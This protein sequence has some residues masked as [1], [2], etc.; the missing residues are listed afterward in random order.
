MEKICFLIVYLTMRGD[1]NKKNNENMRDIV[2]T[3]K[4]KVECTINIAEC[5]DD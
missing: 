4:I 3:N 2:D 1:K 5:I